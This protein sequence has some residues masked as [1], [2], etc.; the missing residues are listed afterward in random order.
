MDGDRSG[1]V[2]RACPGGRWFKSVNSAGWLHLNGLGEHVE[3]DRSEC[4]LP[5]TSGM[6]TKEAGHL[7]KYSFDYA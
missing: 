4:L 7:N 2:W 3:P 6:P 5:I 1:G